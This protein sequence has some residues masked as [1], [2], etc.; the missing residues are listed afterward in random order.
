M[1]VP[2]VDLKAE[3]AEIAAE[4]E[5]GLARV[6]ER[7]AFIL[8]EEVSA[9]EAEFAEFVGVP[10]CL[11]VANGTDAL[12]LVLRAAGIG[13]GDEVIVPANTFIA[14]A[15]A[16]ARAGATPVFVD[17]DPRFHLLAVEQVAARLGPRT[18]A[19]VPVHLYGQMAPME[20]LEAV[21][22]GTSVVLIEDAAQAHGARGRGEHTGRFGLAAG[23]SF[24]PSKN[25]GAYGDGGAVYTRSA[26][27]AQRIRALRNYGSDIRYHHPEV[28][29]N[30][31]LDTV[32]AVVLRA[33]LKRLAGWNEARR[34]AAHRYEELLG[35]VPGVELPQTLPGNEHVWHLYVVRVPKRDAVL[36]RLRKAGVGAA[37]HYPRPI[38]LLGAFRHLGY[39]KGEFPNAE[40]AA[41]QVMSLP[42]FPSI[43][44]VQ[45]EYV[46]EA[47]REAV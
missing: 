6:I 19:I 27:L 23:S 47:L 37:V 43:T 34:R 22:A 45:Q 29:F 17:S 21:V 14:T 46:A 20:E 42:M 24:Y 30:S 8:G 15:L 44:P 18:R 36:E 35:D 13:H 12:E 26:E 28:G 2:L 1:N 5:A 9:F 41:E 32:Q 33:K 25:L 38:H 4:V 10:H 31:R 11:G 7:T 40:A 3:H 16:V 39:R